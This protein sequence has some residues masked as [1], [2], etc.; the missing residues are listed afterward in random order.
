MALPLVPHVADM[1]G[2]FNRG[3]SGRG[4]ARSVAHGG[5]VSAL[6]EVR[7][8]FMS[9]AHPG[10]PRELLSAQAREREGLLSARIALTSAFYGSSNRSNTSDL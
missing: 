10:R 4:N 5:S 1:A 6:A 2:A 8:S 7:S 3:E 9:G